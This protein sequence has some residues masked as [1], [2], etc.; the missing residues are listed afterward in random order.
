M[1]FIT[2]RFFVSIFNGNDATVSKE[3]FVDSNAILLGNDH[4]EIV[5]KSIFN[6]QPEK[7]L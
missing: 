4:L 7:K 1:A 2:S 3:G 6:L 5:K